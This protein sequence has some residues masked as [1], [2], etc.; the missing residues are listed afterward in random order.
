[1]RALLASWFLLLHLAS[2]VNG[3]VCAYGCAEAAGL[4]QCLD[5]GPADRGPVVGAQR[6]HAEC[7]LGVVAQAPVLLPTADVIATDVVAPGTARI[8]SYRLVLHGVTR[9]APPPPPPNA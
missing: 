3:A 1:M 7:P 2:F 5:R 4:T 8:S 9:D 6:L